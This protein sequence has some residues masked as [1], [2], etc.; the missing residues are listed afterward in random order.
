MKRLMFIFSLLILMSVP[1]ASHALPGFDLEAAVGVWRQSPS[2]DL[3]YVPDVVPGVNDTLDLEDDLGFDDE[4][5]LTGRLKLEYPILPNIYAVA[6]PM[7]FEG[8]GLKAFRFGDVSIDLTDP[9][10]SRLTLN[11]YDLALYYG[12]PLLETGTLDKLNID[13]GL[14]AR[15]MDIEI[16][17]TQGAL[18]DSKSATLPLPTLYV[19]VQV[20]P[21]DRF[22]IEAEGRG[23]TFGNDKV[24]SFIGR[25]KVKIFGPVF[26][27][28]GY[29][30]D[31]IDIDEKD[32]VLDTNFSG[33]ILEG[34][35]AL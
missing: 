29:R 26:A 33:V 7:E 25:L 35:V 11:Q 30:Y 6:A 14:N 27:G 5:A 34:G 32:I 23:L 4:T 21:I 8:E 28:I 12:L 15:V 16:E 17:A 1:A 10:D 24:L 13:I 31:M 19:A 22:H 20:R 3:M 2:G 9:F 18:S